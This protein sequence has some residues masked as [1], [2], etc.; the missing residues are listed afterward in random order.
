M[1]HDLD[2]ASWR[3]STF[4]NDMSECVE[5]AELPDGAAVRDSKNPSGAVL[6]FTA[7]EW[8]AFTAGVRDGQFD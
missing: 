1:T 4:S 7:G 6:S 2:S 8:A 5:V 3:K